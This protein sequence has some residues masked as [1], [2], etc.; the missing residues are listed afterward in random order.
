ML[1]GDKME[2]EDFFGQYRDA[3]FEFLDGRDPEFADDRWKGSNIWVARHDACHTLT[4]EPD[5][6]SQYE[7]AV[8][9]MADDSGH[10]WGGF[11][12]K[13][14][15]LVAYRMYAVGRSR[16]RTSL[17]EYDELARNFILGNFGKQAGV[18]DKWLTI[19]HHW[20]ADSLWV[21]TED[22]LHA[23]C[24]AVRIALPDEEG[25]KW[26]G[27]YISRGFL[28]GIYMGGH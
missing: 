23:H 15:E 11:Y 12:A 6:T 19:M 20:A 9:L 7:A 8:R 4:I 3:I 16:A 18:D 28:H 26:G 25:R 22:F 24:V 21:W 13:G 5:R 1:R 17:K 10:K 14:D 2:P 27:Y